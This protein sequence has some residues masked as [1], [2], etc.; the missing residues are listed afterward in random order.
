MIEPIR[1][2]ET[3]WVSVKE[4]TPDYTDNYM[5]KIEGS[6]DPHVRGY[7]TG[8]NGYKS[9]WLGFENVTHWKDIC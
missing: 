5:V 9:Y 2:K 8:W 3:E 6:D 1:K 4:R 7:S